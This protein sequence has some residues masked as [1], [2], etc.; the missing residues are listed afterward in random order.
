MDGEATLLQQVLRLDELR[1][2]WDHVS[3]NQGM[4]GV[5]DVSIRSWR[6]NWEER[7]VNLAG[8]VR[9]NT[10]KPYKLR[11]I[12]IP[13]STPGQYRV[14]RIPSVTD[15]VLQRAVAQ[16]LQPIFER[17]FLDC[18]YGYR[19]GRSLQ[20][21]VQQILVHRANDRLWVLD[22]DIDACFD[23]IDHEL[24]LRFL[25]ADLPEESLLPL[26]ARWTEQ[27]CPAGRKSRG[28]AMGSPLSPLLA[29]VYLHRLDEAALQQGYHL[30]RYADDFIVLEESLGQVQ[31]AYN[32]IGEVLKTLLLQYEPAKTRFTSFEKGFRF[33]GVNF[34]EDGYSYTWEDKQIEVS[35]DEVDW[36]FGR[37]GPEYD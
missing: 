22:A 12:R 16:V 10:Y 13:K 23:S 33:V 36:L 19:P 35:G 30:V 29:N 5:D 9:A 28:I 15:R 25:Q 17:Q 26:I 11:L 14:L 18:S 4:P 3:D 7:L 20:Q 8:A 31:N 21:A 27:S 34:D 1:R 37:Y 2:A 32:D 24:L 6:R